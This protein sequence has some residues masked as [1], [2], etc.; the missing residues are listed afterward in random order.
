MADSHGQ[1][2][3]PRLYDHF[4]SLL[5]ALVIPLHHRDRLGSPLL[6]STS[7]FDLLEVLPSSRNMCITHWRTCN[8]RLARTCE[9]RA[10]FYYLVFCE[11]A[12]GGQCLNSPK[13]VRF[14]MCSACEVVI[15]SEIEIETL[16]EEQPE[17]VNRL[18]QV[19]LNSSETTPA[20]NTMD[21]PQKPG[22]SSLAS[23]TAVAGA[24]PGALN[25]DVSMLDSPAPGSFGRALSMS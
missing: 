12:D 16:P 9:R 22:L 17:I 1:H 13:R 7:A 14:A 21:A 10:R 3:N 5:I 25:T 15:R 24:K 19:H 4:S 8:L 23:H 11:E 18:R 2:V 6:P 20:P